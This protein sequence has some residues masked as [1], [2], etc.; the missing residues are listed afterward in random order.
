MI[1]KVS[2]KKIATWA[3][4]L[5][6]SQNLLDE[7][8]MALKSADLPP[9]SWYDALLELH[10][11]SPDGL[12]PFQ[13]Q[14]RMLLAQYNLSRLIDRLAKS[15]FVERLPS[16]DDGRGQVLRITKSGRVMLERMWPTYRRAIGMHFADKLDSQDIRDFSRILAKLA[17]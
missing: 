17:S 16:A 2:E 7:V 11:A 5:R 4:F 15:G 13:L 8:E 3:R 1:E 12:R 10:L 9:L 14:E 6:V